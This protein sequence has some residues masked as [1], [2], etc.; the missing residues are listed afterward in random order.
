MDFSENYLRI[1]E[2]DLKCFI[3]DVAKEVVEFQVDE[4]WVTYETGDT[5]Y[6]KYAQDIFNG[7]VD[8]YENELENYLLK[9]KPE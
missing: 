7:K 2:K 5:V 3:V 1:K 4:P 8:R 6:T 9:E